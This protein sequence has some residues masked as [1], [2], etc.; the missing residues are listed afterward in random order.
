MMSSDDLKHF[1]YFK[2]HIYYYIY[3]WTKVF[4][5]QLFYLHEVIVRSDSSQTPLL[6]FYRI[7]LGYVI[8]IVIIVS[9]SKTCASNYSLRKT[10]MKMS[11]FS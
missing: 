11:S 4:R 5:K 10:S 2:N 7:I 8:V 3:L 1:L 6:E 9:W